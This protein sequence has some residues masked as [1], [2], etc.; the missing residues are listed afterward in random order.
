MNQPATAV[1]GAMPA[2]PPYTFLNSM[3]LCFLYQLQSREANQNIDSTSQCSTPW[4]KTGKGRRVP[5]WRLEAQTST[6]K[7]KGSAEEKLDS[8]Q[9]TSRISAACSKPMW[10]WEPQIEDRFGLSGSGHP[11]MIHCP[12]LTCTWWILCENIEKFWV[13]TVIEATY[14]SSCKPLLGPC[15]T[16]NPKVLYLAEAFFSPVLRVIHALFTGMT[17]SMAI[18]KCLLQRKRTHIVCFTKN[19]DPNQCSRSWLTSY[20]QQRPTLAGVMCCG[21]PSP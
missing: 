14:I 6:S 16:A 7:R 9:V 10:G 11:E 3:V 4:K 1:S 8:D 15:A 13:G 21:H 5:F 19:F 17:A 12:I 20:S 18:L 2:L